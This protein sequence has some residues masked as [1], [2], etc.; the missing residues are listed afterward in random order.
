ME[1]EIVYDAATK[2]QKILKLTVAQASFKVH[3]KISKPVRL[4]DG[5]YPASAIVKSVN[6]QRS[7]IRDA[8]SSVFEDA[9]W[10]HVKSFERVVKKLAGRKTKYSGIFYT[11][12]TF[13][14]FW[15]A[16]L[17]LLQNKQCAQNQM[18]VRTPLQY[19]S[20]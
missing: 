1:R 2:Y 14:E 7:L 9:F 4:D 6:W 5:L 18:P 13:S 16:A 12:H 10:T 17:C 8:S 20:K 19:P 3:N 15:K 11:L